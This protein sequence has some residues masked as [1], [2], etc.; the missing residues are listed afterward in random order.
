[1]LCCG[2]D[3]YKRECVFNMY[4]VEWNDENDWYEDVVFILI[5]YVSHHKLDKTC[6]WLL[7]SLDN[8]FVS[9][10]Y[11]EQKLGFQSF[12]VDRPC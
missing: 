6:K 11:V 7:V 5:M 3:C 1:M 8:V 4:F 2:I 9:T 10:V 12:K